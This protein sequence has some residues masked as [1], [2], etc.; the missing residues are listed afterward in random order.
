M[1]VLMVVIHDA[2]VRAACAVEIR[3]LHKTPAWMVQ[4]C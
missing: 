1:L 4:E 3:R 2:G